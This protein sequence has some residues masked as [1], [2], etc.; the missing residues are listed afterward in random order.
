MP[1]GMKSIVRLGPE[2]T[3][4]EAAETNTTMSFLGAGV[5]LPREQHQGEVR[6]SSTF[7]YRT[8]S[9][10]LGVTPR[11][12]MA[13]DLNVESI[14]DIILMA[15]LRT[16]AE[17]PSFTVEHNWGG[18]ASASEKVAGAVVRSLE[19][20][21]S[22]SESPDQAALLA[23]AL[24]LAGMSI[25][26][27]SGI[28]AGTYPFGRYFPLSRA[29]FTLN[30]VAALGV[31]SFSWRHTNTLHLG[32]HGS[33][34]ALDSIIDG[35]AE[36]EFTVSARFSSTAWKAL[37]QSGAEVVG[38]MVFATGTANETVTITMGK[39]RLRAHE[40][41]ADGTMMEQITFKSD[42][43]EGLPHV[44]VAYGS[45]IGASRLGLTA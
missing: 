23:A 22:R 35:D 44:A 21:F 18:V 42:S 31:Y 1:H 2:T 27:A 28:V 6:A 32:V 20:S 43:N 36:D 37:V 19:L 24:E 29:T 25:A 8:T 11:L 12:T 13:L 30:S 17:L 40:P 9:V 14:R 16:N 3:R 38:S 45:A 33:D 15:T 41:S 39:T 10:P 4:G 26:D 7:P 5:L 34:G